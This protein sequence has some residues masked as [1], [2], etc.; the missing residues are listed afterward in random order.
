MCN[1]HGSGQ[2]RDRA[3]DSLAA[4]GRSISPQ[5][6]QT[7]EG[8]CFPSLALLTTMGLCQPSPC[9]SV[10]H[11]QW[12]LPATDV[13]WRQNTDSPP[14]WV[15]QYT[16]HDESWAASVC[17]ACW[18][19]K[20][21]FFKFI[22]SCCITPRQYSREFQQR[23]C[24]YPNH[25]GGRNVIIIAFSAEKLLKALPFLGTMVCESL[26]WRLMHVLLHPCH[27]IQSSLS[28]GICVFATVCTPEL[29]H[30]AALAWP[31]LQRHL[32][33]VWTPGEDLLKTAHLGDK[34]KIFF[35]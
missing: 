28:P 18:K 26:D 12:Y 8:F 34:A 19:G 15:N 23:N 6:G 2:V 27:L 20:P 16:F 22:C 25:A 7:W 4:V 1:P 33:Y 5:L 30:Q 3:G 32:Q 21:E 9:T 11:G 17:G 14:S 29:Q 31:R 35:P 13:L 10:A 24:P